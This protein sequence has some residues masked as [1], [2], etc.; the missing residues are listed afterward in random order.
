M[1]AAKKILAGIRERNRENIRRKDLDGLRDYYETYIKKFAEQQEISQLEKLFN[2]AENLI[3]REDLAFEDAMSEIR[4]LCWRIIFYRDNEFVIYRFNRLTKNP[5]DYADQA[6]FN[7]LMQ[8]GKNAI[9][10]KDFAVLREIFWD[11]LDLGGNA[12]DEF[13]TANIIKG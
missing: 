10:Q 13:L 5:N 11:I 6:S 8:A 2:R 7:R 1:Q 3:E 12:Q 4:G 9:V